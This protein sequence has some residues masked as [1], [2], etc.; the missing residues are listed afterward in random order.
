MQRGRKALET[1]CG[2]ESMSERLQ[3]AE[4]SDICALDPE[5]KIE[6]RMR[7][8]YETSNRYPLVSL[9]RIGG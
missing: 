3:A 1:S 4:L 2:D 7:E 5:G 8:L 6:G 9:D